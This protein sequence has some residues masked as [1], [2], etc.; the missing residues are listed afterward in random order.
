MGRFTSAATQSSSN[1]TNSTLSYS[2]ATGN[3]T[4]PSSSSSSSSTS[5]DSTLPS[6]VS[7]TQPRKRLVVPKVDNVASS[8]SGASSASLHVYRRD[9]ENE[10]K[11]IEGMENAHREAQEDRALKK[12]LADKNALCEN[13]T[14]KKA[15]KRRKRKE[16]QLA[17]RKRAKHKKQTSG[18]STDS[19]STTKTAAKVPLFNKNSFKNDG[20]FLAVLEAKKK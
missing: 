13:R 18:D 11:R 5:G 16:A 12:D 19:N 14:S 20:S 17:A 8:N 2:E 3:T 10:R 6:G 9:R 15:L 1:P 4:S 7:T